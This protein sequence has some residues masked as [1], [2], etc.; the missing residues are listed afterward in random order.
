MGTKTENKDWKQ[1]ARENE[2]VQDSSAMAELPI[3]KAYNKPMGKGVEDITRTG[4]IIIKRNGWE[5]EIFWDEMNL[6]ILLIRKFY[7]WFVP[8]INEFG[9]ILK[10]DNQKIIKDFYYTPE[11]DVFNK[12][13]IPLGIQRK[14]GKREIVGKAPK[15]DFEAYCKQ[16][17]IGDVIN[18]LFKEIKTNEN[19][20]ERYTTSYMKLGYVIYAKDL[21][22]GEIYKI[23]PWGSYGRFNQI[24]PWTFEDLKNKAKAKYKE[25]EGEQVV[26]SFIK[27][28]VGIR[29]DWGFNYLDWQLDWFIE[30]SNL[31]DVAEVTQ[32]VSDFNT[33]RFVWVDFENPLELI[34]YTAGLSLWEWNKEAPIVEDISVDD[35]PF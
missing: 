6:N 2:G 22:T 11:V 21:D 35:I 17:K 32:L 28:K 30:E 31:E 18:P 13:N 9:D 5:Y 7:T 16:P 15:S 25:L 4:K 27:T 33:E 29:S 14:G 3:V 10:D 12:D 1:Q 8:R 20:G 26:N 34:S 23:I 19:T 24:E